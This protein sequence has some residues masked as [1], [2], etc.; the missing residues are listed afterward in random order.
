MGER[1]K[2]RR[3]REREREREKGRDLEKDVREWKTVWSKGTDAVMDVPL[4]GV[5]EIL[6]G[7]GRERSESEDDEDEFE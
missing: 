3:D 5:C 6:Y 2:G 4:G 7:V 1:E